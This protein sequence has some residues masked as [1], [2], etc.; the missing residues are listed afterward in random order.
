M[1]SC[2]FVMAHEPTE[3]DLI[4]RAQR[5]ERTAVESL[6]VRHLGGVETWLRAR[7]G[8]ESRRWLCAED[9]V[10]SVCADAL[11]DLDQ[12]QYRGEH[13][14]RRW[15]CTR[16]QNKLMQRL[17]QIHAKQ[18]DVDLQVPIDAVRSSDLLANYRSIATPSAV[19]GQQEA[20]ARIEAALDELPDDW[21]EALL[22]H[23]LLGMSHAEIAEAM[24]K[25][26]GAVR[27]LVYRAMAR[28]TLLLAE[29]SDGSLSGS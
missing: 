15:L 8:P 26:E 10:Q 28:L 1:V 21:R 14:L 2:F 11:A 19:L 23:R 20:L 4:E 9:L 17:R 3:S 22:S 27:N 16:A 29:P 7:M 18:R 25:S 24:D 5:G 6:M 12:F 13:S